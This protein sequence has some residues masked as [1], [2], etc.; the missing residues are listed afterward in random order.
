MPTFQD[1]VYAL[2]SLRKRP[3]FTTAALVTLT[4]GIGANVTVFT[5]VNAMLFRPLPFGERSDR[6]V[7]VHST[8]RLQAGTGG[9]ATP[10]SRTPTSLI[11]G[12]RRPSR[13]WPDTCRATSP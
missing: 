8:H 1:L 4:V 11:C 5:I 9:G 6:V 2:R 7:T 13:G 12:M 3:G 10:S